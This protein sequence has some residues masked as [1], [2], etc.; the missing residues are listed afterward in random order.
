MLLNVQETVR[1]AKQDFKT[2]AL[3]SADRSD[4]EQSPALKYD[5]QNIL[6]SQRNLE[7]QKSRLLPDLMLGYY[8]QSMIGYQD[9]DGT[10]KY[11]G[12]S[13][14][15]NSVQ[16]GIGIPLFSG[17]QRSRI[18]S[19]KSEIQLAQVN[20]NQHQ[21]QLKTNYL[22]LMEQYNN[23]SENIRSYET[24]LLKN[25]DT[26]FKIAN[27]QYMNGE[28]NY[29]EWVMLINQAI[30]IK[31]AYVDAVQQYNELSIHLETLTANN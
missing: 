6:I 3:F 12:S 27:Q 14:R 22:N 18:R 16:A 10:P 7:F 1:P 8:N 11:Y 30:S 28:I 20:F 24:G 23:Q 26:I 2:V 21:L 5:Q 4:I 29:L 25:T 19:S 13:K 31:S 15:F 17:A 9:V